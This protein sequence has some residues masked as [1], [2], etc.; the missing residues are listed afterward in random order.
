MSKAVG[1]DNG[2]T[3]YGDRDFA[4]YLRRSSP[5]RASTELLTSRS[6]HR[7]NPPLHQLPPQ[8]TH[9]SLPPPPPPAPSPLPP[10]I[11]L[12]SSSP[13]HQT[14]Q[15]NKN[16]GPP[17]A[18]VLSAL[19][20]ALPPLLAPPRPPPQLVTGPMSTGRH[21]GQRLGACTD[22]RSFWAK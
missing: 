7:H 10:H 15:S 12:A 13:T 3:N 22:C 16:P 4:R 21:R 5:S 14:Y 19:R 9:S 20:Q 1:L 6:R 18:L 17:M 2:L 8:H 11:S